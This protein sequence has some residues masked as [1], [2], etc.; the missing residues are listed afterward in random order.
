MSSS[1]I[2]DCRKL[3]L[4]AGLLPFWLMRAPAAWPLDNDALAPAWTVMFKVIV[5]LLNN[6]LKMHTVQFLQE[7]RF[8]SF[9]ITCVRLRSEADQIIR[10]WSTVLHYRFVCSGSY[11]TVHCTYYS[12]FFLVFFL[13][14]SLL[15]SVLLVSFS[16]DRNVLHLG[17]V[18]KSR[19]NM[20][21]LIRIVV[22]PCSFT[23]FNPSL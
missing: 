1:L 20:F 7:N 18:V 22:L 3:T 23:R 6:H 2:T 15:K 4:H 17:H 14:Y 9:H 21:P 16:Q 10:P 13:A 12:F 8:W 19:H 11:S 5:L